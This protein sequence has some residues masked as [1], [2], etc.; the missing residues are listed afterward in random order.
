MIIMTR[1]SPVISSI[2][3]VMAV[4][5]LFATALSGHPD[6]WPLPLGSMFFALAA[7]TTHNVALRVTA[8]FVWLTDAFILAVAYSALPRLWRVY[9]VFPN[10]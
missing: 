8:V 5:L 1:A 9:G 2:C 4:L 6:T 7:A 3:L 10:W